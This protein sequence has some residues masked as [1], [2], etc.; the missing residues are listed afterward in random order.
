MDIRVGAKP[1]YVENIFKVYGSVD[2]VSAPD[3]VVIEIQGFKSAC[4][5]TRVCVANITDSSI[6]DTT[7]IELFDRDPSDTIHR[8]NKIYKRDF[9]TEDFE[10]D[11]IHH[12]LYY[13]SDDG[14]D[15]IWLKLTPANGA[16]NKYEYFIF[17]IK[18]V[19]V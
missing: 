11:F 13:I 5:I 15:R 12:D 4:K 6:N 8:W 10:D 7:T 1:Q 18:S 17:G 16:S 14:S 19:R 9:N 2:N 3:G